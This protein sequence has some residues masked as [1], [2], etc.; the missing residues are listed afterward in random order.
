LDL[1]PQSSRRPEK[2]IEESKR[3]HD[4]WNRIGFHP[5]I[6]G[7][8]ETFRDA[9]FCY[10]VMEKCEYSVLDMLAQ[11]GETCNET[12]YF[13]VWRHMLFA[14]D[15]IHAKDI[16][17]RDVKPANFLVDAEGNVKICDFGLSAVVPLEGLSGVAGTTPFM[18]PEIVQMKQYKC[19]VDIWSL[20]AMAFLMLYGHYPYL[21]IQEKEDTAKTD[22]DTYAKHEQHRKPLSKSELLRKII[23]KGKP[24]PKYHSVHGLPAPSELGRK[25]VE[26]LLVRDPHLRPTASECLQIPAIAAPEK[27]AVDFQERVSLQQAVQVTK[28]AT[29]E[30]KTVVNPT[31]AKTMDALIE[32]LQ[33]DHRNEFSPCF[34]EPKSINGSQSLPVLLR[35]SSDGLASRGT[36]SMKLSRISSL[37][38]GAT[39]SLKLP[40]PLPAFARHHTPDVDDSDGSTTASQKSGTSHCVRL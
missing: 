4:V 14:L 22:Q 20:G 26:A 36:P 16:A 8:M 13:G 18:A 6:V 27:V 19:K 30:F 28:Q 40:A 10:F 35:S 12:D 3:E 33:K 32:Q 39:M 5:N 9:R 24:E 15:F 1:Q 34:S 21:P 31:V 23:A 25:F 7:L 17:H 2:R 29:K 11:K 37:S 38:S